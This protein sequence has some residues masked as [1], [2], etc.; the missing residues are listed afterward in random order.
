MAS[1][2]GAKNAIRYR[3]Y[4]FDTETGL[5]YLNARYYD[6]ETGRF[7]SPD[8]VAENGNLYAYCQN[9][10]INN[11][12]PSGCL[13][14]K[15][16]ERLIKIGIGAVLAVAA[17]TIT[18]ATGGAALPVV[19]GIAVATASGAALGAGI[20][21][22]Q[23]RA[24][25]GSWDGALNAALEGAIDGAVDGFLTGSAV[26]VVGA[27]V[28]AVKYA[29]KGVQGAAKGSS[30]LTTIQ[31]GQQFD[32]YGH[33][34]GKFLT[35]TGTPASKLALPPTNSGVK[36]T[37]QATKNFRAYTGTIADAIWDNGIKVTGGG[38]QYAMRYS[39]ET[40]LKKGWLI[41]IG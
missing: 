28:S 12:D 13:S 38:V 7:I 24:E 5:Y 19:A 1:T 33:L 15:W 22:V 26:A 40:L 32:R 27:S 25:T 17:V 4:Y 2:V 3:G 10:P 41:I 35:N 36:T 31:K 20:N 18:V 39:I 6:P 16:K 30:H 9:D 21:A 14:A 23:H 29:V 8:V 37:L 34:G 11:V